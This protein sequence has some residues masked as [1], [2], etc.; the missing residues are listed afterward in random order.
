MTTSPRPSDRASSRQAG[1]RSGLGGSA[2][3]GR[4]AA[5]SDRRRTDV[6]SRLG[7][8]RDLPSR[9]ALGGRIQPRVLLIEP[10][11]R[12]ARCAGRTTKVMR[13]LRHV[14]ALRLRDHG[15]VK[16]RFAATG[17]PPAACLSDCGIRRPAGIRDPGSGSGSRLP[18]STSRCALT[19]AAAAASQPE[20]GR[21]PRSA[22][23]LGV[24][25]W[26]LRASDR[27]STRCQQV[28]ERHELARVHPLA[29]APSR[30]DSADATRCGSPAPRST[31]GRTR[32]SDLRARS[33]TRAAVSRSRSP[34]R[35][36]AVA[37][38]RRIDRARS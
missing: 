7:H 36:L 26:E 13:S 31:A 4:D 33:A 17:S 5:A 11:A 8:H 22:W 15:V 25:S 38:A 3:L 14:D 34:S 2:P 16:R 35:E 6:G 32:A 24:G 10:C 37:G 19:G 23:E 1:R 21:S 20:P 27:R 18:G 12:S 28:S 9:D 30:S 29:A